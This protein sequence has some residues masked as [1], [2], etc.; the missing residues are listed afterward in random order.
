MR[1]ETELLDPP[2]GV[3]TT[4]AI[5]AARHKLSDEQ[6]YTRKVRDTYM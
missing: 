3:P 5:D 4:S 6:R 2:C 1:S